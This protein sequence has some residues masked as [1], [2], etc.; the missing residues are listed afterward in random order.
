MINKKNHAF[1]FAQSIWLFALSYLLNYALNGYVSNHVSTKTYGDFSIAINFMLLTAPIYLMGTQSSLNKYFTKYI[2]SDNQL[3]ASKYIQWNVKTV[4]NALII[5]LPIIFIITS[6]FII[7]EHEKINFLQQYHLAFFFQLAAPIVGLTLL[8][9]SIFLAL[10]QFFI[11]NIT[12]KLLQNLSY[13]ALFFILFSTKDKQDINYFDLS[14]NI[15]LGSSLWLIL[16]LSAL[17]LCCGHRL[18]TYFSNSIQRNAALESEWA[19]Y[20]LL[21]LFNSSLYTLIGFLD[22]L[23]IELTSHHGEH[24]VG[25]YAAMLTITSAIMIPA[26][27]IRQIL[28]PILA[29]QS[30]NKIKQ[31]SLNLGNLFQFAFLAII[32]TVIC[33]FSKELL[34]YF[35][36]DYSQFSH[37]LMVLIIGNTLSLLPSLCF[38]DP[39]YNGYERVLLWQN[40]ASI[41]MTIFISTPCYYFFGL[42]GMIW[43]IILIKNFISCALFLFVKTKSKLKYMCFL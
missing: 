23:I 41:V 6:A 5:F 37:L 24:N 35:G 9:G 12:L 17:S 27:A 33:V 32:T 21:L 7:V 20:G 11:A 13:L 25:Y 22:L 28:K 43:S 39:L 18:M 26:N 36:S 30:T 10:R 40:N 2:S 19:K 3:L 1:F 38:F 29:S 4:I 42:P 15:V 34:H 8:L 16:S 14:M 31:D